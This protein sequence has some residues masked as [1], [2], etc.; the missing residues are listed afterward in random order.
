MIDQTQ[1]ILSLLRERSSFLVV[2]HEDPDSDAIGSTLALTLALRQMG[3][4]AVA[5]D[6]NVLPKYLTWLPGADE[7]TRA[8]EPRSFE[9]VCVLDCGALER[10]GRLTPEITE[11]PRVIN[12][13]HHLTN[14]GFGTFNLVLP[15]SSTAEILFELLENLDLPLTAAVATNLYLGIYT[16]TMMFQNAST[17]SSALHACGALVEAGADFMT[18]ARRVYIETTAPRLLLLS[19]V[20]SSLQIDAEGRIAGIVCTADDL[21]A[22]GLGPDDLETFVEYPRSIIGV[23]AAYM[24][25]EDDAQGL[26]KGSLRSN[27]NFDV[28]EV[29]VTFGGGGHKRAA[30]FKVQGTLR[31]IR[32]RLVEALRLLLEKN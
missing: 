5:Y 31:Q 23:Q 26:I 10:V 27:E 6:Q 25:R 20:L 8:A 19:R 11:H 29:A 4:R 28:S 3:K 32:S 30:G 18:I 16:D 2:T 7:I 13:D 14:K 17:S 12:I 21:H 9:V 15:Y 22:L 1:Q 24:L